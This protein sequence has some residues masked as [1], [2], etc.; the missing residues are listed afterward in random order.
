MA[1]T[2]RELAPAQPRKD[3]I[4]V[5][6]GL[7]VSMRPQQWAKNLIIFAAPAF[8]LQFDRR[9]LVLATLAFTAFCAMSAATYLA[10]DVYDVAKDRL[11]PTKR[12]R[13]IAAGV[14]PQPLAAGVAAGLCAGSIVLG[15]A[16]AP[17]LVVALV[18]YALLQAAYNLRLKREPVVDVLCVSAGFVTRALGGAAAT[19]VEVSTWFLLC[20]ALLALFMAIGKRTAEI[21][22]LGDATPTREVL[23]SYSL[24][25]LTRMESVVTASALMSYSLWAAQRTP[26]HWLLATVPIVAYVMF[27]YQMLTESGAGEEP[28]ALLLKTPAILFAGLLWISSC[29]AI[30]LLQGHGA[31]W[32]V[33]SELC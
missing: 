21:R 30:L 9:T 17:G 20:V 13:P 5:A 33:C 27:R 8:A 14:V 12:Y 28:D 10:N 19:S 23:K 16:L 11:H 7:L 6:A 15:L 32:E 4:S 1:L 31:P 18:T 24:S 2:V 3:A 22:S 29:L 26:K 25:V